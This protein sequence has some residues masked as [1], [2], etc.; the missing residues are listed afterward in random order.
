[1]LLD[2][3]VTLMDDSI[4]GAS[5]VVVLIKEVGGVTVHVII[6]K[7]IPLAVQTNNP[8]SPSASITDSGCSVM[9]GISI[10]I[11]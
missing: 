3:A 5:R 8:L 7:G 6:G 9:E 4:I 10:I 1:M 2:I 11:V